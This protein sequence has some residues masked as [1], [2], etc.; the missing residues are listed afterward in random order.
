VGEFL[1]AGATVVSLV[2]V[3][4]LRLRVAVPERDAPSV[5]IGQAVRVRVEGDSQ[6]HAGR[7]ARISPSLQEQNRTL[8]VEA[9]V[10][11][12]EGRLRPGAFAK[13]EIVVEPDRTAVLVP[14]T[15]IVTFAG[16]E[17]VIGVKDG[18]SVER[19]VRTGRK[20]GDRVEVLEGL[21]AGEPVVAEPGNLIGG[22]P[23]AVAQ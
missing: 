3:H 22:Q 16:L 10:S 19:R 9:E 1:A 13:A 4:P 5:R 23:V 14:A 21:S 8:V 7:V 15:A 20:V 17:K 12:R 6:E 11:N 18:R 2:K